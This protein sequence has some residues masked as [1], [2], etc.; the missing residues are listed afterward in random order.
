MGETHAL[1]TCKPYPEIC[2]KGHII[3]QYV[4]PSGPPLTRKP[5][6]A[7]LEVI[8]LACQGMPKAE[9]RIAAARIP[10]ASNCRT[11][12]AFP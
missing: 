3:A 7:D 2:L 12:R 6:E 11:E 4:L 9:R 1:R 10:A 5:M 8:C